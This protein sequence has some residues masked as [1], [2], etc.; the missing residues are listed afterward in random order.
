[1]I[2]LTEVGSTKGLQNQLARDHDMNISLKFGFLGLGMGGSSIAAACADIE[3]GKAN[4]KYPYT[5]LL[6][7]T[8]K[9]DLDK[10]EPRNS[11]IKKMTIGSGKGA[12][13]NISIGE[14]TF[15]QNEES[16]LDAVKTQFH[17]SDFIWVVAG[18]GGGTGTGSVIKA[19]KL[20][21]DNGFKKKFGLILTLPR[22]SEGRTVLSNA[23]E[24]LQT[25][26]K[27]M[28]GLGSVIIVD[29]QKLYDYYAKFQPNASVSDYLSFSNQYVAETLHELNVVTSS[30][31]PY[32]E[33][34]F[35]SSEFE[36]LVKTPGILHFA[37]FSVPANS[38]DTEQSLTYVGRLKENI[39][40]G[41]LSDGYKL[42]NSS[43]S[44]VSVV[45]S[46]HTAKRVFNMQFNL[47]IET[48][49]DG[50]AP[51]AT[52]KPV[53][54]YV[55]N[56]NNKNDVYFYAVFA[57]LSLPSSIKT[58]I[59]ENNKLEELEKAIKKEDDDVLSALSGFT[60]N[61]PE[62]DDDVFNELSNSSA[63]AS[64]NTKKEYDPFDDL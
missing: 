61:N 20:L 37:K 46:N 64:Q 12:G 21:N 29:N 5:S 11:L 52:E 31:K 45:T 55:Y 57:G 26:S 14:E 19:A 22:K 42:Q 23:L 33:Y 40:N 3:M 53:A 6:I 15:I 47:A 17:D 32:G 16:I 28:R 1:M 58:L 49:I 13:R 63:K 44:A 62:E 60:R 35:D 38:V 27:V 50:I 30:F 10:I 7:N 4:L 2:N 39:E 9:M 18:L 54:Q 34:H 41:V 56:V 24:R 59:E 51:A 36:N 48:L 8:N 43:R 25:I